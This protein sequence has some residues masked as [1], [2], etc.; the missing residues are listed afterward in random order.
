MYKGTAAISTTVLNQNIPFDTV[1][2]TNDNTAYADGQILLKTPG[3]YD[4]VA[5][6]NVGV[7]T[8]ATVSAAIYA[9]GVQQ[10]DSLSTFAIAANGTATYTLADTIRVRPTLNNEVAAVSV[11]VETAGLTLNNGMITVEKRK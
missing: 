1:W 10:E 5:T 9:D 7:T 4:V 2:N 8:A 3:Y 11:R 6:L